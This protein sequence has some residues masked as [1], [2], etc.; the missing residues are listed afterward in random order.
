ML[1]PK[2]RDFLSSQAVDVELAER[3]GVRSLLSRADNPQEGVWPNW[4]NFPAILFPWTA[5]DGRIVYQVRPDNPTTDQKTGKPRKYVFGRGEGSVL[6][7]I[8]PIIDSTTDVLIVEGTKQCLAAASN[9]PDGAAVYGIA[10]CR[11]WQVDGKPID[12]LEALAGRRVTVVLDADAKSNQGVYDA[13]EALAKALLDAGA[14]DVQFARLEPPEDNPKAGL[15]DLLAEV[16]EADRVSYLKRVIKGAKA[17]PADERPKGGADGVQERLRALGL[18]GD[19]LRHALELWARQEAQKALRKLDIPEPEPPASISLTA[20]LDE[21]D[22]TE[23][24]RVEGLIPAGGNALLIAQAKSGKTTWINNLVRCLADWS[25]FLTEDVEGVGDLGNVTPLMEGETLAIVDLELDR[26][27]IRRWLRTQRIVNTDRVLVESLRGRTGVL[28][29]KDPQRRRAWAEH[30]RSH[31]VKVLVI[32]CLGP[33]LAFYGAD[34]NS[35]TEV[36]QLL[37]ALEALK[38]ESGVEELILVHH[39]GHGGERARGASRLR[40]WP[41]VEIRLMVEGADDPRHEPAPDAPR[42]V[43]ARGRDVALRERKLTFNPVNQRLSLATE[44]GNRAQARNSAQREALLERLRKHPGSTQRALAG[45]NNKLKAVLQELIDE[46]MVHTAPGS[47]RSVLHALADD[48]GTP[49]NCP[50]A[51][52]GSSLTGSR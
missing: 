36:G 11:N 45:T 41:D 49:D 46:G 44:G 7:A 30:L 51:K 43:A 27:T 50:G 38:R 10:G 52:A 29:I 21:P 15:D 3:M 47:N 12:D 17:A 26:R 1:T 34:E 8:A 35:N 6:W 25:P 13:G 9:L 32:D 4:A 37:A 33:L 42:Y 48:C 28:D 14:T 2:H 40:D 19:A 23:R 16:G 39:A 24:W 18:S 31:N 22:E 5:P 20:L